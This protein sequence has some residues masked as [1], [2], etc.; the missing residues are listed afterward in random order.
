MITVDD[1]EVAQFIYLLLNRRKLRNVLTTLGE[2][3]V[4]ILGRFTERRSC[5]MELPTSFAGSATFRLSSISIDRR[6][7]I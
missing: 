3:A 4:L 1:L 6:T 2:K 5:S 7:E